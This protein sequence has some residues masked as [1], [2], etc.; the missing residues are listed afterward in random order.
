MA[1][2]QNTRWI[3]TAL[4]CGT[5]TL[6]DFP[7]SVQAAAENTIQPGPCVVAPAEG[8]EMTAD[9]SCGTLTVL[10]YPEAPNGFTIDLPYLRASR[11]RSTEAA[12]VFMLAGGPGSTLLQEGSYALFNDFMLGDILETRDIIILEERGSKNSVPSLDCPA[13]HQLPWRA[14]SEGNAQANA[15]QW[16]TEAVTTCKEDAIASGIDLSHFNSV[17]MAH[18]IDAARAAFGFE[19]IVVYGSSYGTLLAQH[20]VRLFPDHVEAVILDGAETP[21]T[22]S[23]AENRA[24]G[25]DFSIGQVA[26]ECADQPKCGGSFDVLALIDHG[27]ALFE[28]GP[29]AASYTNPEDDSETINFEITIDDFVDFIFERQSGQISVG[30]LPAILHLLVD[31]GRDALAETLGPVIGQAGLSARDATTGHLA[32]LM[33]FAVVCAE[34]PVASFDDVILTESSSD[35]AR[36]FA[37][38]VAQQYTVACSVLDVPQL[39]AETDLPVDTDAPVLILTGALDART[40]SFLADKIA[41]DTPT[42]HHFKFP[43]GTHVQMGEFNQCAAQIMTSFLNDLSSSP[44]DAC[45]E[46]LKPINFSLLDGTTTQD[47]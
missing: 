11:P 18:D 2:L 39:S 16:M 26:Q 9:V 28:A 14:V 29:I 34:D 42:A 45:M 20:Y 5:A 35:Y 8:V 7:A 15:E 44:D 32:T 43:A 17:Q 31:G 40:P 27:L 4:V 30:S 21:T 1:I 38:Q 19:K 37:A 46:T 6:A 12:P 36:V 25:V 3:V 33:H 22:V 24:I 41:T 47:K 23:W 13:F 10:Q